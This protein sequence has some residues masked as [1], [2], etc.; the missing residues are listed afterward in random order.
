MWPARYLYTIAKNSPVSAPYSNFGSVCRVG[1]LLRDSVVG[2]WGWCGATPHT[3]FSDNLS[4]SHV[5][6]SHSISFASQTITTLCNVVQIQQCRRRVDHNNSNQFCYQDV[7]EILS[8]A[9]VS[10]LEPGATFI[11]SLLCVQNQ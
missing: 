8:P 9:R 3:R 7:T 11:H 10:D 2:G 4:T 5:K 1:H 6:L